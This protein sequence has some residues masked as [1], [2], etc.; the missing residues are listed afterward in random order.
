[1]ERYFDTYEEAIEFLAE[2]VFT[3]YKTRLV[4]IAKITVGDHITYHVTA[5]KPDTVIQEE[6][7]WP[8]I[9]TTP[10]VYTEYFFNDP[11][12]GYYGYNPYQE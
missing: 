4:Q 3:K 10:K 12:Y 1:M 8:L 2:E 11:A 9:Q 6:V 5:V 7:K